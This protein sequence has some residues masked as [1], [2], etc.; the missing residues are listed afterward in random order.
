MISPNIS[1]FSLKRCLI[2]GRSPMERQGGLEVQLIIGVCVGFLRDPKQV[3][4]PGWSGYG[5]ERWE[6]LLSFFVVGFH[7]TRGIWLFPLFLVHWL[8]SVDPIIGSSHL[9][10]HLVRHLAQLILFNQISFIY[11]NDMVR[12]VPAPKYIR[13][14]LVENKSKGPIKVVS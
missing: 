10:E 1:D 2:D 7:L 13:S 4:I 5:I 3:G 6:L 12:G 14:V 11:L 9:R 8:D